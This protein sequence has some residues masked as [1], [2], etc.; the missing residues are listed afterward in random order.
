MGSFF[1]RVISAVFVI[2]AVITVSLILTNQYI[3]LGRVATYG[4]V[5][6]LVILIIG[7][8]LKNY[9]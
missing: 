3:L 2:Y 5:F 8:V 4:M 6:W 9:R 7:I 1:N